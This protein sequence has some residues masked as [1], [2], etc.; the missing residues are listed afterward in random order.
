MNKSEKIEDNIFLKKKNL[1]QFDMNNTINKNTFDVIPK[2]G[3]L[4]SNETISNNP[5]HDKFSDI[6]SDQK[7]SSLSKL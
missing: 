4:Y 1:T 3:N 6:Y 7:L 2:D 5:Y